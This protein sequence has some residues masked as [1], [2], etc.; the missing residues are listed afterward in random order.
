MI[1]ILQRTTLLHLECQKIVVQPTNSRPRHLMQLYHH[2]LHN[3]GYVLEQEVINHI[4]NRWY[5][6]SSFVLSTT[7]TS[8]S[9]SSSSS[10]NNTCHF[11]GQMLSSTPDER[12]IHMYKEYISHHMKWIQ[13]DTMASGTSHDLDKLWLDKAQLFLSS[14]LSPDI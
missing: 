8:C 14:S 1:H 10:S 5:I 11:L 4:S 7:E 2:I 12:Q 6:T 13:S 9:S 3:C